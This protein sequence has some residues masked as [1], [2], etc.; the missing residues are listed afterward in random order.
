M[1]RSRD[2]T[3]PRNLIHAVRKALGL[4]FTETHHPP[5]TRWDP[6]TERYVP[7]GEGY[8]GYSSQEK[9]PADLELEGRLPDGRRV[10]LLRSSGGGARGG[11]RIRTSAHRLQIEC[12]ECGQWIPVGRYHQ[13]VSTKACRTYHACLRHEDCRATPALGRACL[14]ERRARRR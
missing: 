8:T 7:Y 12:P 3:E 13:H 5:F 2:L 9:Y 14:A 6:A 4:R 11:R 10:R 1:K